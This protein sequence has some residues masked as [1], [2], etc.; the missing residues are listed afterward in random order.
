MPAESADP[1]PSTLLE[2]T[3][4]RERLP[5]PWFAEA[6]LLARWF[7]HHLVLIPLGSALLLARRVDATAAIDV[8]LLM[9]AAHVGNCALSHAHRALRPVDQLL[10]HLWGRRAMASTS[11]ASRFLAALDAD[12]VDAMQTLFCPPSATSASAA[13]VPAA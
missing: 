7:S 6:T 3:S 1:T 11:A 4:T 2:T 5:P 13:T 8:V 9:L 12:A 10:P